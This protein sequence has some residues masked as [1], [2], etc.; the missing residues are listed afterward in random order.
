MIAIINYGLGNLTS[1]Q[2]MC[3]RLGINAVVTNDRETI[4]SASK[5]I[6][7]GVGHFKKGMENLHGSG[8][9]L[10]LDELVLKE[11]KPI[12]GKISNIQ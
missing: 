8:L 5:I 1:I 3:K 6:L 11:K 4:A 9:K 12:L 2:N 10:L 7:P